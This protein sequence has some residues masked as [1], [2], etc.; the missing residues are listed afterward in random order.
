M[1]AVWDG[2]P[3]TGFGGLAFL[4]MARQVAMSALSPLQ[5]SSGGAL[6]FDIATG[7]NPRR[8]ELYAMRAGQTFGKANGMGDMEMLC[9]QPRPE[10]I[11]LPYAEKSKV[12][13]RDAF[14]TDVILVLDRSTS[15]LRP[16]APGG[17]PKNAAAIDAARFFIGQLQLEANARG[18]FDQVGIVGFNDE[19]W[20]EQGLT[21]DRAAAMAALGRIARRTQEGTRLDLAFA[22]GQKA[23]DGPGRIARNRPVMIVLTDGLPNRVPFGAGSDYPGTGRQEDSVLRMAQAAKDAGTRIYTI[24]L[25]TPRDILPWLLIAAATERS[26]YYY[27]PDGQDLA[28]IYAQ[29]AATFDACPRPPTPRHCDPE[30]VHAD[31]VLILDMSTSMFRQTRGGRTKMAAAVAAAHSFVGLLDLERDGWGRQDQLGVVGFNDNAWTAVGL[32]DD[33]SAIASA[34]DGLPARA[35]EGTRLDLALRQ[36]QAVMAAGPRL[37]TNQPVIVLMTDGLPNRV[38]FGAGSS[39]PDCPTQECTVLRAAADVKAAGTRLFTI[40]LGEGEDVLRGLLEQVATT[41]EDYF[42]APDGEDLAAIYGRVAG[43][44]QACP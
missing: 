25:G 42:F 36:G 19:A 12:C 39:E 26:M 32:G 14:R 5:Y 6:W 43:R 3:E 21:H 2:H 8:E 9:A 20:I 13:D 29:I 44:I 30:E 4:P 15:M 31:I 40:G 34:I 7:K 18:M 16:V 35:A 38:P 24:G 17:Q 33:G 23:L 41:T 28:G 37:S 1:G 10:P 11:Y 27:A 22:W